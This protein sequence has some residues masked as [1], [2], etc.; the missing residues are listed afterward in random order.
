MAEFLL[1]KKCW[2]DDLDETGI[3]LQ[4]KI[5][6]DMWDMKRQ[7]IIELSGME[8]AAALMGKKKLQQDAFMAKKDR[9]ANMTNEEINEKH[10]E[11]RTKYDIDFG[12]RYRANDIIEVREDGYWNHRGFD[13]DA[14]N[15]LKVPGLPIN[16]EYAR[17]REKIENEE[18]VMIEKRRYGI[19]ISS[20]VFESHVAIIQ[21]N[22]F[23]QVLMDKGE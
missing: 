9:L 2:L 12:K 14:F 22:K 20:I 11:I 5:R 7:R 3:E 4:K 13:T 6:T 19:D 17:N 10:N 21:E 8:L 15:V 16:T 18:I 23:N 1:L